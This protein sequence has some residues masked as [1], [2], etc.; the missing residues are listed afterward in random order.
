[1]K[2]HDEHEKELKKALKE[3]YTALLIKQPFRLI[4]V[5]CFILGAGFTPIILMNKNTHPEIAAYLIGFG[6]I[7]VCSVDSFLMAHRRHKAD[8]YIIA[9]SKAK[10]HVN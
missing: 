1:M 8:A 4:W 5:E 10:R 2:P 3:R 9:G 6:A 7:L